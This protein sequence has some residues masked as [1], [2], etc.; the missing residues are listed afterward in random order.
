MSW[1]KF[2]PRTWTK[3]HMRL[4]MALNKR[5]IPFLSEELVRCGVHGFQV[6]FLISPNIIVEIDGESH[7]RES[8]RLKDEWKDRL[9]GEYGYKV[10][11]FT[12][13]EVMRDA[14]PV[15]DKIQKIYEHHLTH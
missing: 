2:A 7:L 11:R 4:F 5:G 1:L 14:S 15:A 3:P 9:L 12:N 13:R 8:R 6:D 10:L